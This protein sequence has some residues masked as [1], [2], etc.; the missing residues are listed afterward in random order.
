MFQVGTGRRL[1]GPLGTQLVRAHV[2]LQRAGQPPPGLLHSRT[3]PL[4]PP[5]RVGRGL[6]QASRRPLHTGDPALP[7]IRGP[8]A[9]TGAS[10]LKRSRA[11]GSGGSGARRQ[12]LSDRVPCSR[13]R[14]FASKSLSVKVASTSTE[15]LECRC[16][17]SQL[18][19][20]LAGR[21]VDQAPRPDTAPCG[22]RP[23]PLDPPAAGAWRGQGWY[24]RFF[25]S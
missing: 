18:S 8:R 13:T 20:R 24:F 14:S 23:R 17:K 4:L 1:L 6:S 12:P 16:W 25:S 2:W 9:S 3:S 11:G 21:R 19:A 10:S 15:P 5:W 7:W 22:H